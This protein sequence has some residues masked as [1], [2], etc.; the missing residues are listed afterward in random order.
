M[1]QSDAIRERGQYVRRCVSD[2]AIVDLVIETLLT[3]EQVGMS[4][5]LDTLASKNG[6]DRDKLLPKDIFRAMDRNELDAGS[7]FLDNSV[8]GRTANRKRASDDKVAKANALIA[9][10]RKAAGK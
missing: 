4:T 6:Y 9:K 3:G 2:D 8:D 1:A 5:F 10:A 7:I